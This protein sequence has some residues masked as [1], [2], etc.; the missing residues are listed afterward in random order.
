MGLPQMRILQMGT[1][2]I[3]IPQMEIPQMKIPQTEIPQMRIP[4]MGIPQMGI[5][6]YGSTLVNGKGFRHSHST[7][8]LNWLNTYGLTLISIF[9]LI[10]TT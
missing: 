5:P 3:E 1:P 10:Q 8:Q 9:S 6:D 4:Q 7:L 2:S